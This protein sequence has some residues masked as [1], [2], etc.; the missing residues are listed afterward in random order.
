MVWLANE[1]YHP[2]L[3][4]QEHCAGGSRAKSL[5]S[6]LIRFSAIVCAFSSGSSLSRCVLSR[7]VRP[8]LLSFQRL[9]RIVSTRLTPALPDTGA[10]WWE[11]DLARTSRLVNRSCPS[12]CLKVL[13]ETFELELVISTI[14]SICLDWHY[15]NYLQK[16]D[17]EFQ[18]EKTSYRPESLGRERQE[19]GV[20]CG[21]GNKNELSTICM[22]LGSRTVSSEIILDNGL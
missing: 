8:K 17:I 2:Q 3:D 14:F 11:A 21:R 20:V 19:N 16:R 1:A 9:G 15:H 6:L 4:L 13:P 18:E 5:S 22:F 7:K 10:W 12:L